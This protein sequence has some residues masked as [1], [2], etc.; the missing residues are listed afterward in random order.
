MN[1]QFVETDSI[2]KGKTSYLNSTFF[3]IR[4]AFCFCIWGLFYFLLQKNSTRQDETKEQLLTTK[5]IKLSAGFIPLFAITLTIAAVDWLM[6]LDAHWYSTIFGV[7][8][9]AGSVVASLAAVTFT[10]IKLKEKGYLHP[11]FTNEQLYSLGTLLFVFINFWAYIA[12]SQY[13]LIWYADLP[14]ETIWFMHRWQYGWSYVSL[15]LIL[16][17]FVVPYAVLL[18]QPSKMDPKRLKFITL[19][20]LGA[21]LVDVF[22]IVMPNTTGPVISWM[23]FIFPFAIIGVLIVVFSYKVKRNNLIPIG[24]PKLQKSIKIS[25]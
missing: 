6:S 18:S 16:T 15:F 25:L 8:F 19:W 12:F 3:I 24:D 17:H 11:A 2:L 5:N 23:D 1:K 14:E 22:W 13:M 9:F 20:I 10:A 21:H 4:V 7:Y